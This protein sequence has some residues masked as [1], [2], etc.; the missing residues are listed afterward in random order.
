MPWKYTAKTNSETGV[1]GLPFSIDYWRTY[2]V[3]YS[4][5]A[6]EQEQLLK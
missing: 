3:W 1:K 5:V 2:Q 4:A 6:L